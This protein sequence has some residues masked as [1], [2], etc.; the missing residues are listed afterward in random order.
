MRNEKEERGLAAAYA[1]KRNNVLT[2]VEHVKMCLNVEGYY[3]SG[4]CRIP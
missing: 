3:Y 2:Y 4:S 1:F